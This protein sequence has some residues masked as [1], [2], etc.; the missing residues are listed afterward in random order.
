MSD[1][2]INDDL[3]D[4]ICISVFRE[5]GARI[6]ADDPIMLNAH[7][8]KALFDLTIED[9]RKVVSGIVCRNLNNLDELMK[10]AIAQQ[11]QNRQSLA[12][13][14]EKFINLFN[15]SIAEQNKKD[16]IDL[17]DSFEGINKRSITLQ[18]I[19]A[20]LN[21]LSLLAIVIY[22]KGS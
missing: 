6:S 21:V 7:V 17:K 20:V 11:E 12:L 3:I 8:M 14:T 9:S 5:S 2:G 19:L 22:V 4:E 16:A 10:A 18:L 13:N 15:E 1:K